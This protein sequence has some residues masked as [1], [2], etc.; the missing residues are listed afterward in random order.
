[1]KA[2]WYGPDEF[3]APDS[4]DRGVSINACATSALDGYVIDA[5]AANSMY[6]VAKGVAGCASTI[7]TVADTIEELKVRIRDLE[8]V[9]YATNEDA[10]NEVDSDY[11]PWHSRRKDYKLLRK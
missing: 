9:T 6:T 8:R 7:D 10:A 1:M 5:S 2:K 4:F 3:Y 11:Y